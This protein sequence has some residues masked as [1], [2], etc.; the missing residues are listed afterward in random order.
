MRTIGPFLP[1]GRRSG[2]TSS[3]GSLAGS[4]SSRRTSATTAVAYDDATCAST[5]STGSWTNITSAS[6]P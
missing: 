2:S 6:L 5:P 1:S 3:G 4:D